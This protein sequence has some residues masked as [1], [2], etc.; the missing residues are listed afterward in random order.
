M[1]VPEP[2]NLEINAMKALTRFVIKFTSLIVGVLLC[3]DRVR[4]TGRLPI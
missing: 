1:V 3:F 4:F 2:T